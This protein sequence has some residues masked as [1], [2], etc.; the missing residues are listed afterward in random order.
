M[1]FQ[2]VVID[3]KVEILSSYVDDA[4]GDVEYPAGRGAP[5]GNGIKKQA[6]R[7]SGNQ[8]WGWG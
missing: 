5:E 4:E 6:P 3:C 8:F 7:E 1:L 2:H